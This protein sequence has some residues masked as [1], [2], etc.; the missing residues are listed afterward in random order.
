MYVLSRPSMATQL[1][2]GVEEARLDSRWMEPLT[3]PEANRSAFLGGVY[4]ESLGKLLCT[5][6]FNMY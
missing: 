6:Y 4:G 2:L 5:E 1:P 3:Q